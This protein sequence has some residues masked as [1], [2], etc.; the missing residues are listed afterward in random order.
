[1]VKKSLIF[2]ILILGLFFVSPKEAAAV[3]FDLIAP[4]G[5]LVRGQDVQFTINID[6]QGT[7][8]T[9]QQIGLT[10]DTQYLSYV[11]TSPGTSMSTVSTTDQGAGKLLF[12]GTNTAGFSG[13][14][15]FA[16]VTLKLIATQA[17]ST[18]LCT[19]WAPS[20]TP[21]PGPSSPPAPTSPAAPTSTP[22]P[23]PRTGDQS[24]ILYAILIGGVLITAAIGL[25]SSLRKK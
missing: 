14:G 15:S 13:S 5:Q 20:P 11:S 25:R 17:G 3:K 1:M 10:Y 12:T 16:I 22:A 7:T 4:S 8:V 21:T 6:T 24:Q 23:A 19:L 2:L 9:S 18:Q